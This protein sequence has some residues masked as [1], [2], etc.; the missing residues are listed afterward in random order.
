MDE[1]KTTNFQSALFEAQKTYNEKIEIPKQYL[2]AF[3]CAQVLELHLRM[4]LRGLIQLTKQN[5]SSFDLDYEP[6]IEES[7]TAG[8]YLE[9]IRPFLPREKYT[10]F[11]QNVEDAI[12][13]RDDF[14]HDCFK[15]KSGEIRIINLDLEKFY[16]H[17]DAK[18]T[19]SQW[20]ASF[21]SA[22]SEINEIIQSKLKGVRV[23]KL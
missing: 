13:K 23:V 18:K 2:F 20:V 6:K 21:S 15:V 19:M 22:F 8:K 16:L 1:P 3:Y 9:R 17:P 11:Y 4:L 5:L 14:I 10:K 7:W 12:K